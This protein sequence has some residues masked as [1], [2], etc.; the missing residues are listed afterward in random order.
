MVGGGAGV[1]LGLL[2]EVL[3]CA[4]A[5]LHVKAQHGR[6]RSCACCLCTQALLEVCTMSWLSQGHAAIRVGL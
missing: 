6:V 1:L 4:P 5:V 3:K 2:G